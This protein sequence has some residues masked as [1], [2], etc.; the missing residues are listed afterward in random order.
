MHSTSSKD[1]TVKLRNVLSYQFPVVFWAASIFVLSGMQSF[2][3]S[4]TP[5]GLD[6]VAHFV[7][8]FVFCGL[9]WRAFF[10]Q[11]ASPMLKH[12]AL[13]FAFLVTVLYGALDEF[14]QLFVPSRQADVLD[15]L[16]DACG[17]LAYVVWH[18]YRAKGATAA[19]NKPAA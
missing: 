7:L 6:K 17:A 2:P 14:H 5:F 4:R 19:E 15:L 10:H 11:S 16:A 1:D 18:Y 12:R 8:F 9:G 3:V 13:L